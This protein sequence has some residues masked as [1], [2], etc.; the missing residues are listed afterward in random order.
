MRR[1]ITYSL[2]WLPLI[3][4][5]ENV[6]HENI[7]KIGYGWVSYVDP[8]LSPLR[9]EGNEINIGNEWWQPY[10]QD[11][12]LGKA[13][14]LAN[15]AHVGR[16][17]IHGWRTYN[18][19]STN[20]T[21]ALGAHGGW[22]SYYEWRWLDN[23]LRLHTGAY[24]ETELMARYHATNVNKPMNIDLA[25][26]AEAMVGLS[27]SFYGKKTS[28]RLRYLFRTNLIGMDYMPQYWQSYYEISERVPADA[29]FTGWWN[30]NMI[31]HELTL[32]FQ[33]PHTTWRLGA[34]HEWL[35]YR[36]SEQQYVRN[37][38]NIIVGCIWH[39]RT[40]SNNK[41]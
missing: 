30:H 28:Y 7:L 39:Y 38:V 9:Y 35:H 6:E 5:A 41:L 8:Y 4:M 33:F 14:K 29:R 22:G 11:T 23:R 1:W 37:Q 18:T 10:R 2:L 13:G 15:W 34:E 12:K 16:L 21:Y 17:D 25:I 19:A 36:S 26:D 24:L 31:R 20:M 32:D 27:W 3:V 40:K